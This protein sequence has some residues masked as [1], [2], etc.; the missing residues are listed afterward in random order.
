MKDEGY[1]FLSP[2]EVYRALSNN[3]LPAKKVVWLTFDDSMID[4]YNV[5][6]PILKKI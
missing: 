2:E 1:Y 3:E 4:F 5:A 6:Y